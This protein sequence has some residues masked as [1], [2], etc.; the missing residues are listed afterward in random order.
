MESLTIKNLSF[1]YKSWNGKKNNP[2]F[3]HLNL[4]VV[5]GEK[6]L[7][8]SYPE[9]GKT[10]LSRIINGLIPKF[11]DGTLTGDVKVNNT[12]LQDC[13]PYDLVQDICYVSQNPLEMFVSTT[14]ENEGAFP[15]ESLGLAPSLIAS[16]VS[17]SLDKW[18]LASYAKASPFELSGGERKR[19]LLSVS[20]AIDPSI[21]VLDE[22]F[23]DLDATWR[24]FLAREIKNSDK[25]I[26]TLSARYLRQFEGVF[27]RVLILDQ[28][29]LHEAT[30]EEARALFTHKTIEFYLKNSLLMHPFSSRVSSY[31]GE[32]HQLRV[33]GLKATRR[34]E[35]IK[36]EKPFVLDCA[37]FSVKSC[38]VVRLIGSNGSGKSTFSRIVCGLD[39]FDQ[40]SI[41]LQDKKVT[42]KT[43]QAS[44]GYLFQNPDYQIFLPTVFEELAWGLVNAGHYS[45]H[46][47]QDKVEKCAQLFSLNLKDTPTTMSFALRKKLQAAVYYLLERPFLIL[48]ELDGAMSYDDAYFIINELS[49]KGCALIIITH[50]D[51]FAQEIADK[52][53]K[54]DHGVLE[55]LDE[56]QYL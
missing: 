25:T 43:L 7:I 26:I 54:V 39:S 46:E 34:R 32:L 23:D 12:V 5:A 3:T 55:V 13:Q 27:D 53:Y 50:D 8:L 18:G 38:E 30:E 15:L 31:G 52:T 4:D 44:V 49:R 33:E 42:D 41:F 16:T 47:I 2:L 51:N 6:V 35:S 19:L 36:D 24:S 17:S 28:G 29:S 21:Y 22:A 40:G 45:H 56:R 48:D 1:T 9:G 10:T 20:S 37:H 14:C 11:I